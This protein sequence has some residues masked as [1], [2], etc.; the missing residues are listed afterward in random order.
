MVTVKSIER[1]SGWQYIQFSTNSPT[2]ETL[3]ISYDGYSY[4]RYNLSNQ[5][6]A[7]SAFAG[8]DNP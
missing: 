5:D 8:F 7:P 3:Y 4:E 6:S 2:E 1:R